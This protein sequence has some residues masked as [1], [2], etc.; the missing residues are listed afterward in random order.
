MLKNIIDVIF[1]NLIFSRWFFD[2]IDSLEVRIAE[3]TNIFSTLALKAFLWLVRNLVITMAI[4]LIAF[5]VCIIVH[6]KKSNSASDR[7]MAVIG[8]LFAVFA[9]FTVCFLLKKYIPVDANINEADILSYL[10]KLPEKFII[11]YAPIMMLLASIIISFVFII[12][13]SGKQTGS[14]SL[15]VYI[16][17]S[18][19]ILLISTIAMFVVGFLLWLAINILF[20]IIGLV[21][22][23]IFGPTLFRLMVPRGSRRD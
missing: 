13:A 7:V 19:I 9:S 4:I 12:K 23:V 2:E 1:G 22:L 17:K 14:Q 18:L 5:I 8:S 15:K 3:S 16:G 6:F 10:M 20:L 11:L 21:V